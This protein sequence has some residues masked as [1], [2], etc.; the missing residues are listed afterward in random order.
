VFFRQ[1]T[2]DR[3]AELGVAGWVRNRPDRTVELHAE[4]TSEA[5][6]RLLAFVREGPRDARVRDVAVDEAEPEGLDA[7]EVR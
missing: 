6:E 1:A 2:A 5:V 7:F 4:G 3:A